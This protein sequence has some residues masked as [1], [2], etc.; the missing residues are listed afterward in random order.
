MRAAKRRPRGRPRGPT[1]PLSQRRQ[2]ILDAAADEIRRRDGRATMNDIAAAAG[3]TK[4]I[5]Y[6]HFGDKSG[7]V[8]ALGDRFLVE[9]LPGVIAAFTSERQPKEMIRRAIAAFVEVI[10]ENKALWRYVVQDNFGDFDEQPLIEELLLR[11]AQVLK[12]GLRNPPPE[13]AEIW[14]AGLI[15]QVFMGVE[16]WLK[17]GTI[18]R[19]ALVDELTEVV[20][21]GIAG[22]GVRKLDALAILVAPEPGTRLS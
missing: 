18:P 20:W 22:G 2:A 17:R 16:W 14:A 7:L 12:T 10:E 3:V 6:Q 4:P 11:L 5:L 15:A 9:L 1:V 13:R 21:K 19:E 8:V